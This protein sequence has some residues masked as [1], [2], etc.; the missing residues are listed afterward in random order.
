MALHCRL[1]HPAGLAAWYVPQISADRYR[2]P[3][4]AGLERA[5]GRKVENRRSQ[6]PAPALARLHRSH[7]VIIGEDPAIGPEPAAYV[8]HPARHARN[9]TALLGGPLEFASVDL[10]ERQIN[11]TRV[12]STDAGVRWNFASL[13]ALRNCS[14]SFPSVHLI[15]GRVNFK[16]GDTKSVF[17]LLNTDVD[18]WPPSR[19]GQRPGTFA[20]H[21]EPA[22]TDRPAR[23]F[24]SFSARGQ[25]NPVTTAPSPLDVKLEKSELE[26]HGHS[27]RRQGIR[28]SR[29]HLGRR[30]SRRPHL[31]R[32]PCRPRQRRRYSR[33]EPDAPAAENAWPLAVGGYIN[34]PGQ[35]I[36]IAPPLRGKQS[37][38]DIRYRRHRLPRPPA[39]GRHRHVQP[40]AHVAAARHRPQSRLPIPAD[41]NY[42]GMAQG[43]IGFAMPEGVPH[44]EGEVRIANSMFRVGNTPALRIADA[45]L[46]FAGSVH[47]SLP[48]AGRKRRPRVSHTEWRVSM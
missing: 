25:W 18:L 9:F 14:P 45:D 4:Q 46:R 32:R 44:M 21:A 5:L 1:C 41:M 40:V 27:L 22:R 47:H 29:P 33:L 20:V 11:L 28:P 35:I 17:Y 48:A 7:D 6:V 10:E 19:A 23:G 42:D 39:M 8:E 34:V 15:D 26:R 3:I 36:E 24:G 43:A 12:E 38:L 2:E 16:F 30:P 31:A 37:P 13:T